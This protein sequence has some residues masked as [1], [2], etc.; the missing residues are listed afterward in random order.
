MTAI[1]TE[2]VLHICFVSLLAYFHGICRFDFCK[3]SKCF[4]L[5][6]GK[7]VNNCYLPES[8]AAVAAKFF[9]VICNELHDSKVGV[10][11]CSLLLQQMSLLLLYTEFIIHSKNG[12]PWHLLKRNRTVCLMLYVLIVSHFA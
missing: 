6:I 7:G 12:T 8:A 9:F 2:L 10:K 4:S 5:K 3:R 1:K 11:H